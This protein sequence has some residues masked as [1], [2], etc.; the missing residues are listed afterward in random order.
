MARSRNLTS[1]SRAANSGLG[2]CGEV[3]NPCHGWTGVVPGNRHHVMASPRIYAIY[4]DEYFERNPGAVELMNEFFREILAGAY[5]RQLK[6]YGVGAGTLSGS[7][8]VPP[9]SAARSQI[10]ADH[11]EYIAAQLRKWIERGTVTERPARGERNPL[12]VI[13]TPR[14][15]SV[16]ECLC[17]YHQSGRFEKTPGDNDL[18]WATIQEWHHDFSSKSEP[19]PRQMVD[20][21]TWCVTH[22]M[23]EAFTNPDGQG[24]HTNDPDNP[25]EGCEIGDICEC[26]KGSAS[27]KTPILKAQVDG[28]W[29]EPYWDNENQSCYPLHVV[30]RAH[31]P[32][33][34]YEGGA[35]G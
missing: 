17:G 31:V 21:C 12:Y 26:A 10:S 32:L 30:P 6:Q 4:W 24:Y 25:G 34:G 11:P 3:N 16:G 18:F 33:H 35:G 5:M 27:M 13:F 19:S 23:V 7:L 20:S 8:V 28:W 2:P 22:E 14:G 15:T 29:V 1:I 9:D